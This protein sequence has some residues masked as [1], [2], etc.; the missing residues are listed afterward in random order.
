MNLDELKP[1]INRVI[2]LSTRYGYQQALAQF[3]TAYAQISTSKKPPA[4][5][6][7]NQQ[8]NQSKQTA[9][10]SK[11][12]LLEAIRNIQAEMPELASS[13]IA[14][15]TN[16]DRF[17]GEPF[18]RLINEINESNV[19]ALNPQLTQTYTQFTQ[20]GQLANILAS[21]DIKDANEFEEDIDRLNI[22]FDGAASIKT[23][24]DLSKE[25]A[26]WNQHVHCFSRLAKE[27]DTDAVISSIEKGSLLLIIMAAPATVIAFMKAVDKILDTIMKVNEVKKNSI[28]LKK[29][30]LTYIDDAINLLEKHGKLN[31]TRNAE[32][33]TE[34]L[35]AE[36]NWT[37]AD[38]LYNETKT[39]TKTATKKI[40]KFINSGGK[41]EG[42]VK[43]LNEQEPKK[44]IEDVKSKNAKLKEIENQIK[45]LSESKEVLLLEIGDDEIEEGE[46]LKQANE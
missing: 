43:N 14:Q 35:L 23:L 36:Y 24:K 9:Q 45:A 30:K 44:I 12:A 3:R 19:D 26:I 40:I 27:N 28:E 41:V 32:E 33:I 4:T 46:D 8:I 16:M 21:F 5:A 31:V 1:F 42:H 34:A 15:Q 11:D 10:T 6:Q 20:L 22:L 2:E 17:F 13:K 7:K 37:D 25:S 29:L 18:I 39:A 38:E